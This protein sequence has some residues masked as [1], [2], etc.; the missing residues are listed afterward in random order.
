M[1]DQNQNININVKTVGADKAETDLNKVAN[2]ANN[3]EDA[4]K[5]AGKGLGSLGSSLSALSGDAESAI[6]G[7][8][9]LASSFSGLT[10]IAVG[11]VGAIIAVSVAAVNNA[12]SM[13]D[14]AD[15][16][17]EFADKLGVTTQKLEILKLIADENSGS[18]D[19]MQKVYDKLSKSMSKMDDDNDKTTNAF[20]RL[21]IVQTE[22]ANLSE[23]EIA[24]KLIK[25]WEDMG[26]TAQGTAAIMQILGPSF[27]DQ[28]PAL[29]AA[30]DSYEEYQS[31]VK[32][33]SRD[34]TD[35]IKA[36]GAAN[37]IATSNLALAWHGLGITF[38][39]VFGPMSFGI[40]SWAADTI[41]SLSDVIQ[42]FTEY[43][44]GISFIREFMIELQARKDVG[45]GGDWKARK[46]ELMQ[47]ERQASAVGGGRGMVNPEFVSQP[48]ARALGDITTKKEHGGS[49]STKEDPFEKMLKDLQKRAD[50]VGKTTELEKIQWENANGASKNFTKEQKAQLEQAAKLKDTKDNQLALDKFIEK[51]LAEQVK[52]EEQHTKEV[53]KQVDAQNKIVQQGRSELARTGSSATASMSFMR[54]TTGMGS[55]D[56]ELFKGMQDNAN[57]A[58]NAIG[59]L[60]AAMDG[61]AE[62]VIQIREEERKSNDEL[63]AAAKDK[64][65]YTQDWTNGAKD[66]IATYLDYTLDSASRMNE[67]WSKGMKGM[68]DALVDFVMTGKM[69]FQSL[70]SD[71]LKEVIR[72]IIQKQIMAP[73]MQGLKSLFGFADGGAFSGGD[74]VPFA[75]GGVVSS[76]TLFGMSGGKTGL[77]GEAGPEA[78]MPLKRGADGAL[79]VRVTGGGAYS[80][81]N[82]GQI[83]IQVKGGNT[84]EDTG[85]VVNAAVLRAMRDVAKKEITNQQ[86]L[87]NSLNRI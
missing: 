60:N 9:E 75:D 38:A 7:I 68:E 52:R 20:R 10:A 6:G 37:E 58:K 40:K 4:G 19:G 63:K 54:N 87:G 85:N 69:S 74:V 77:M 26:R 66:A 81:V 16:A 15:A 11:A 56:K 76:P 82:V 78:I 46:D 1:A 65:A 27:R 49:G 13:G 8:G 33:Y 59:Q 22:I 44:K 21:G 42:A 41:K 2:A 30:G 32:R 3:A 31:R 17:G 61:Y 71:M 55:I 79:G 28:I 72:F 80:G 84:N 53:Q 18:V 70:I 24:G 36:T 64:V 5:S 67:M 73:I 25:N 86:R 62:R 43:R 57:I 45:I 48:I 83:N 34:F 50:L 39:D 47:N 12:I 35:D 23:T 29:K 51:T 14:A